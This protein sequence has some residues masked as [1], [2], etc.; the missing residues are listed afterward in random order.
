MKTSIERSVELEVPARTAY[1][2]WTQ[3]TELPRYVPELESVEQLDERNVRWK[4]RV[5]GRQLEG[6]IEI[7]EQI[8]DKRIA[9]R[10]TKGPANA[11]VLTF[12]RLSDDRSKVMLQVDHDAELS[13][14][15][16]EVDL[17]RFKEFIEDRGRATGS[18]RGSIPSVDER[19]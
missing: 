7:V 8:P 5:R 10:G 17:N 19:D 15:Q 18:W 1:D 14:D 11:G 2:Q 13:A 4:A 9:W 6:E 16:V 12:H 3:L